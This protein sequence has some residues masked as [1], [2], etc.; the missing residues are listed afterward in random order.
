MDKDKDIAG[1]TLIHI[2]LILVMGF[3]IIFPIVEYIRLALGGA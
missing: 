3:G 1:L 2:W